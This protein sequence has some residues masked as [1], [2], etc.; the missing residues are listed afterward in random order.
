MTLVTQFRIYV[1]LRNI[2]GIKLLLLVLLT[3]LAVATASY[4]TPDLQR[5]ESD[6]IKT[7]QRGLDLLLN[8]DFDAAVDVFR[9]IGADNPDSP[10]DSLLE[11]D[12]IWWKIYL[13]TGNL[14]EP[15]VFEVGSNSTSPYDVQFISLVDKAISEAQANISAGQNVA[16][17]YLY[18]G[19]AYALRARLLAMRGSNLATARAAKKM[20]SLL[21]T[22]LREDPNLRD[23]YLGLGLY[24]YFVDT[25]PAVIK[26]LRPFIG[27]PGGSRTRG[28]EEIEYSAKYGELTRGEALFYL[29]KDYSR[30]NEK[31]LAKSLELFA[32]LRTQY[33]RNGL[34]M[35]LLGSL[36]I[37]M[38][39]AGRG[40]ALY[41]EL[42]DHTRGEQTEA[43]KALHNAA[44]KALEDLHHQNLTLVK[45][46][47]SIRASGVLRT[48]MGLSSAT[49]EG[50]GPPG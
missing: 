37:H 18:E 20:R 35:L 22:A 38:G 41:H 49:R 1:Q 42:L 5:P 13:T 48:R 34:W 36:E 6:Q 12:A 39:H 16:R 24:D 15:D 21:L 47:V 40:E 30:A 27:L 10:L 3:G 17:S 19:L 7:A 44:Q 11:A 46:K 2:E 33:P 25:L 28:L 26:L 23:A 32:Q 50:R 4:A 8:G 14:V 43:G 31:Q 45:S 29:A 9:K